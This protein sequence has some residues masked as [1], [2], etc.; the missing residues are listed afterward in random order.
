MQRS[1][2]SITMVL[3]GALVMAAGMGI[4]RFLYTPI[5]PYMVSYEVLTPVSAGNVASANFI[6]Y[7]IGALAAALFALP[8]SR[9]R[10]LL[11]ALMLSVVTTAAM[12]LGGDVWFYATARFLGGVA[13]AFVLVY[14]STLIL[15]RLIAAGDMHLSGVHFAGVG[16][17]IAL[18][19]VMVFAIEAMGGGW[20]EMWLI[21][22]L[23]SLLAFLV[24]LWAIPRGT[25]VRPDDDAVTGSALNRNIVTLVTAYTLFGFGYVITATFLSAMARESDVLRPYEAW[26]WL[27]VGLAGIP[28]I[29]FWTWVSNRS[30]L[31]TAYVLACLTLAMGVA[32]SVL[33]EGPV[34]V[35]IASVLLGGTFMGITALGLVYARELARGDARAA[36]AW[37]TAGFGLGQ[38]IGPSFA[39]LIHART[40]SF[41]EPSLVAVG[42]ML[43]AAVLTLTIRQRAS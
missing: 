38:M 19:A 4:G 11:L 7:L 9:R 42:A 21:G 17:G 41:T 6:G 8:G 33:G 26:F 22:G 34:P 30:S 14:V 29:A 16:A 18:S 13:S 40:Q 36:L 25:G 24:A 43:L 37:M 39:G 3:G 10:W 2:S 28:S 5:L 27:A 35:L 31:R 15:E 32:L 20:R 23:F 1:G 12:G